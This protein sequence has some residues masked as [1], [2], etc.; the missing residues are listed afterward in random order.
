MKPIKWK[1]YWQMSKINS[2]RRMVEEKYS[3]AA[4]SFAVEH[5]KKGCNTTFCWKSNRTGTNHYR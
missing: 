4:N 1:T 5:W 2:S 3:Y